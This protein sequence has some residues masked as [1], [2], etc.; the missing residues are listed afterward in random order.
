MDIRR[1]IIQE[2]G[3]DVSDFISQHTSLSKESTLLVSTSNIFNIF[4]ESEKSFSSLINLK[5]GND[6]KRLN[7]FFKAVNSVLPVGGTFIGCIE[8]LE[9]RKKRII[10]K[11]PP[12]IGYIY[13]FFDFIFKRV[14]P[15][16]I[17]TKKIYFFISNGRNR[18]LS[19]TEVLG[20]LYSCG[21]KIKAEQFING[22]FYFVCEK[23]IE[24]L[25]VDNPS[26]GPLFSMK[27]VG[28]NG[29]IIYCYKVRTM[30]PYAEYIQGYVYE[31]YGLKNGDKFENDFRVTSWGKIFRKYWIDELPMI[32]N[33][34]RGD[35]KIVGVRPLSE[36]KLSLYRKDLA[37]LR[38]KTRPGLVPPFYADLPNTLDGLMDSEEKYLKA[39]LKRPLIT[40]VK[41][42][43][44]AMYNILFKKARSQ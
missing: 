28:K 1:L 35:I 44:L 14:F 29:K 37:E 13:Y 32:Y 2:S 30:H 18:A 41:Y 6:I 17:V 25:I 5:R 19:K 15:K 39:Y 10:A 27:R 11:F 34:L 3:V 40:D 7:K 8:T 24:P 36:H 33:L 16:F 42:F 26:Y 4:K 9:Q 23:S 38:K 31:T 43:I 21:F 22:Q 12:V 20:R